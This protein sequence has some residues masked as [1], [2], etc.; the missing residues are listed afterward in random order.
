MYCYFKEV[1]YVTVS[2]SQLVLQVVPNAR[3]K[4]SQLD[5]KENRQENCPISACCQSIDLNILQLRME[6]SPGLHKIIL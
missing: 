2:S 1:Y 4:T 5:R 3:K 6:V